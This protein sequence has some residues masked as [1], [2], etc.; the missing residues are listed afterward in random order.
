MSVLAGQEPVIV[1]VGSAGPQIANEATATNFS[2]SAFVANLPSGIVAGDLLLIVATFRGAAARTATAPAGWST[3]YNAVGDGNIRRACVFYRVADGSEGSSVT[4]ALSNA[5]TCGSIAYRITGGSSV[6]SST[7]ATGA[8]TS[9]NP[10]SLTGPASLWLAVSHAVYTSATDPTPPA[11]YTNETVLNASNQ[12]VTAVAV[13]QATLASDD[14]GAFT[15][16]GSAS[17]AA[18][19]AAIA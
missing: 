5:C 19:V 16:P 3:A 14:P 8:S 7:V 6:L 18:A 2:T 15:L 1:G 9:P 13:K 12:H 4:I 17:W 11:G 10:P